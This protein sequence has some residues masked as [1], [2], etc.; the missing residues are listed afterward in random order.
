MIINI[1]C[2]QIANDYY[3]QK[4]DGVFIPFNEAMIYGSPTENI[5]DN[6]FILERLK[7][8]KVTLE[9]YLLKLNDFFEVKD[10]LNEY[11]IVC[12][13][14]DDEFCQINL[15]TLL[16][17]LKQINYKKSIILHVIDEETYIIK[18][19]KNIDVSGYKKQY[20]NYIKHK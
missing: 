17:F 19:T 6:D 5:F 16:A 14:G 15:L 18:E 4:Y 7:T 9:E 2:G 13:F 11:S 8:H 12:W 3:S 20:L 10:R 1:T